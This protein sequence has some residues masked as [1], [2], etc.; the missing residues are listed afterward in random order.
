MTKNRL[1]RPIPS[2]LAAASV[3][4]IAATAFALD[5]G[6]RAP[7][8]GLQDLNGNQVSI[9]SLRGN[10]V[11]VD[12]WASWCE[13]CAEEMPVLE[14]MYGRYRQQGLRIV[15]VSQD[16]SV[17]NAQ[18]FLRDHHVSFPVVHD[19]AHAVA[20]RYSPPSMPTSYIIDRSGVIRHIH[21]GYRSGDAAAMEREVRA[22]LTQH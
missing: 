10:V 5:V 19:A 17:S 3:L 8:I 7:E 6:D 13:P 16:R 11:I 1:L 15:A 2:M 12:F 20:G 18:G 22:L 14:R 9:A 21:R 4:A